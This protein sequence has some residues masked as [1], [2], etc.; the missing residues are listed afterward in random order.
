MTTGYRS[1]FVP[2]LLGGRVHLPLAQIRKEKGG[3][4]RPCAAAASAKGKASILAVII[5]IASAS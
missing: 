3:E 5:E 1:L 4:R 2:L